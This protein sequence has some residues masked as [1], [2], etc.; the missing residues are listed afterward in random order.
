MKD[1]W[2]LLKNV[3]ENKGRDIE[4][5]AE[6]SSSSPWFVGHFPGE[7]ILP[8]IALVR[9]VQETIERQARGKGESYHF[10][11]L[12]RVRFTRPVRPGDVLGISISAENNGDETIF[13]FKV[14]KEDDKE[15]HVVSSGFI[16]A[17]KTTGMIINQ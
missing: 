7:P 3:K 9:A 16:A 2:S 5:L 10:H 17:T 12:R 4:A 14:T 11:S 6:A 8:G 15:T 1:Q 13:S